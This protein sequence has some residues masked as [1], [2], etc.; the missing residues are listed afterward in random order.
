M[1]IEKICKNC[2]LYPHCQHYGK[3]IK[4]NDTCEDWEIAFGIYQTLPQKEAE[5]FIK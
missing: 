5:K 3:E 4:E 2:E 1:N